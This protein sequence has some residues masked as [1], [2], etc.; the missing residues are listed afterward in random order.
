MSEFLDLDRSPIQKVFGSYGNYSKYF[1]KTLRQSALMPALYMGDYQESYHS[2]DYTGIHNVDAKLYSNRV[3]PLKGWKGQGPPSNM[4]G[5]PTE[6]NPEINYLMDFST[7]ELYTYGNVITP[8]SIHTRSPDWPNY[9]SPKWKEEILKKDFVYEGAPVKGYI[10][11]EQH[12]DRTLGLLEYSDPA[13]GGD[14]REN[15]LYGYPD[16]TREFNRWGKDHVS[17]NLPVNHVEIDNDRPVRG[18]P[19]RIQRIPL[20]VDPDNLLKPLGGRTYKN[21]ETSDPCGGAGGGGMAKGYFYT[22]ATDPVLFT[23]TDECKPEYWNGV[24]HQWISSGGLLPLSTSCGG[25][26]S[27]SIS[28][29]NCSGDSILKEECE[30]EEW[31]EFEHYVEGDEVSY[32]G[33]CYVAIE[34]SYDETPAEGIYWE[35]N[36]ATGLGCYPVECLNFESGDFCIE[37]GATGECGN[38]ATLYWGG[39][40]VSGVSGCSGDISVEVPHVK[41]I[42]LGS[43]LHFSDYTSGDCCSG[44]YVE[45]SAPTLNLSIS[46]GE[47]CCGCNGD[48]WTDDPSSNEHGY[49][50]G[51]M[52]TF[53]G[54]C[55]LAKKDSISC[56][57]HGW[58]RCEPDT[59]PGHDG[60]EVW[61]SVGSMGTTGFGNV[62]NITLGKGLSATSS[63][64]SQPGE[65]EGES[66]TISACVPTISGAGC[67]GE[68]KSK[69]T[70]INIGSGLC[71]DI[72]TGNCEATI[73]SPNSIP[74][75]VSGI[76]GCCGEGIISAGA[77]SVNQLNFGSGFRVVDGSDGD[78][79]DCCVG[80]ERGQVT[81]ETCPITI[82]GSGCGGDF[83]QELANLRVGSGLC[84]EQIDECTAEITAPSFSLNVQAGYLCCETGQGEDQYPEWES[85]E[86]YEPGDKVLSTDGKCYLNI[87]EYMDEFPPQVTIEEGDLYW[88]ETECQAGFEPDGE[89][90]SNVSNIILGSG[91]TAYGAGGKNGDCCEAGAGGSVTIEACLPTVS[92]SGCEGGFEGPLV[93]LQVGDGLC[94]DQIDE[95]TVQLSSPSAISTPFSVSGAGGCCDDYDDES[96][97][98]SCVNRI[99]F[100]SGFKIVGG[101]SGDCGSGANCCDEGEAGG[102]GYVTVEACSLTISGSGCDGEFESQLANLQVGDGL[103]L[104]QIDDCTSKI[105]ALSPMALS[106]SGSGECCGEEGTEVTQSSVGELVF[107]NGF[108][109]SAGGE[110]KDGDCCDEGRG[111]R[112]TI[113]TCTPTI[114]GSGCAGEFK[115]E[116]ANL[117]VGGGLC[118][119][120]VD[121]CTAII[122]SPSIS[123]TVEGGGSCCEDD[124]GGGG[125]EESYP[126]WESD[127][128]EYSAGDRVKYTWTQPGPE[129]GE[130]LCFEALQANEADPPDDPFNGAE[131]WTEVSCD[132]A[133]PSAPTSVGGVSKIILGSGLKIEGGGAGSE[134]DCCNEGSAGEVTISACTPIISGVN[135]EGDPISGQLTN[136]G[137]GSGLCLDI[138]GDC[139]AQISSSS[140]PLSISGSGSC[141]GEES[142]E[143]A[144]KSVGSIV[145]GSGF[146]LNGDGGT[147]GDC[148]NAGQPGTVSVE[149]CALPLTVA[150][151]DCSDCGGDGSDSYAEWDPGGTYGIGDKVEYEGSCYEWN[152]MAE[153]NN[154]PPGFDWDSISCGGEAGEYSNINRITF[155][156]GLK[157]EGGG[158]ECSSEIT[159]SACNTSG[160]FSVTGPSECDDGGGGGAGSECE[161]STVWSPAETYY[162]GDKVTHGGKCWELYSAESTP[163]DEPG[164]AWQW[165]EVAPAGGGGGGGG[166]EVV[167][168]SGISNIVLGSGLSLTSYTNGDCNGGGSVVISAC[169]ESGSGCPAVTGLVADEG[170]VSVGDE[171][172]ELGIVGCSGIQT[173]ATEEGIQICFTGEMSGS[174]C[175][176]VTGLVADEGSVS[177]GDECGELGIVGCSGI[178]TV[179]TEG[180]IQICFTGEMSGSGCPAVTGFS[181]DIGSV[182]IGDECGE[183]SLIGCDGIQTEATEGGVKICF[184]GEISG[185]PAITGL[186]AD[187][188][189]SASVGD[190]CGELDL[191]GVG[192][193]KT[194]AVEGGIEISGGGNCIEDIN[195]YSLPDQCPVN[196]SFEGNICETAFV[197]VENPSNGEINVTMEITKEMIEDCLGLEECCI[198][199]TDQDGYPAEMKVYTPG[200]CYG[201]DEDSGGDGEGGGGEEE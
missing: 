95:C 128:V 163:G 100:G 14:G 141:C 73:Y 187:E 152:T 11:N 116:L 81:I 201:C 106:V 189:G 137:V 84:L 32:D 149:T 79:G 107:G 3:S 16:Y 83:N 27:F 129:Q 124:A 138:V 29:Y 34:D 71:V 45:I 48:E 65:C 56:D 118:L 97:Y 47:D 66:V 17:E 154:E 117:Q 5:E 182:G 7:A 104:E 31:Y 179:A 10:F 80:G 22:L 20:C 134:G 61:E 147:E 94:L 78:T 25:G 183:M 175:P 109:L 167:T 176:A 8:G 164:V 121:E 102:G 58:S 185:C 99:N 144:V 59:R 113:E 160:A 168:S 130:T 105:R 92:G 40:N 12:P 101:E 1:V 82:S 15:V 2:L 67:L 159:V 93:N 126:W 156:E 171:C 55:W 146:R 191:I 37:T 194:T 57:P 199:Y 197:T 33:K 110:S 158:G 153:G 193:I 140:Q 103:C 184:T 142:S 120:Q 112:V 13:E 35:S 131:N 51:D 23:E 188:G 50:E 44:G 26:G 86:A 38:T 64:T 198:K 9:C 195:G 85:Y 172:G 28:G 98:Y 119:D 49:Q 148:C 72:D 77:S 150:G 114:S 43:G 192:G 157:L 41:E 133:P 91:L 69:F 200:G 115:S 54:K 36:E 4:I 30:A 70:N 122:S 74:L 88:E 6:G 170:S 132:S 161:G 169:I 181:T 96:S 75:T 90:F 108:L 151:G 186:S 53:E 177:V 178:Q 62:T 63:M 196:L 87:S 19:L 174:G 21:A 180:G 166:G 139:E 60:G 24:T 190:E 135:C 46:G 123:L 111:S 39:F 76:G 127:P 18:W 162:Y 68:G 52:V 145:F 136:F 143:V 125:G 89:S 173:V 165:D 42:R 155:G